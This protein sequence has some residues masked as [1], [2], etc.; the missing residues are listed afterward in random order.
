MTWPDDL[1]RTGQQLYRRPVPRLAAFTAT[2][3]PAAPAAVAIVYLPLQRTRAVSATELTLTFGFRA[4]TAD[5]LADVPSLAV[6]AGLDLLQARR[7]AAV[8]AGYRLA[9]DLAALRRAGDGDVAGLRG[10]AAVEREWAGRGAAAGRAAVFD[11]ALDLPGRPLLEEACEQAG[12]FLHP[13]AG[14]QVAVLLVERALMIALVCARHQGRYEWTKRVGEDGCSA[15]APFCIEQASVVARFYERHD[16]FSVHS[17]ADVI[18][19]QIATR[20][21]ALSTTCQVSARGLVVRWA[22]QSRPVPRVQRLAVLRADS[23]RSATASGARAFT[24]R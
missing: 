13:G 14:R 19:R 7:H 10:L 1:Y 3:G 20:E 24:R 18:A 15:G 11:C 21:V 12:I 23:G 8:L 16:E 5:G 6:V 2:V 17:I 22:V 9:G 4:A